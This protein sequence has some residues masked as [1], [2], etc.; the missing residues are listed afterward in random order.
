[1]STFFY[2]PLCVLKLAAVDAVL[3]GTTGLDA[4][5]LMFPMKMEPSTELMSVDRLTSPF[6]ITSLIQ[7]TSE[8][9]AEVYQ[10]S[11]NML[12]ISGM[13]PFMTWFVCTLR[14]MSKTATEH[15]SSFVSS[16]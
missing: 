7:R 1:M 4:I 2:L 12:M 5:M 14:N 9:V 8:H 16:T 13:F 3:Y 10:S 11:P 15:L 6:L